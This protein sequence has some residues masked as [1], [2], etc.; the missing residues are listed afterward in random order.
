MRSVRDRKTQTLVIVQSEKQTRV[1]VIQYQ[2]NTSKII[3]ETAVQEENNII[4]E[5]A[6]APP[7]HYEFETSSIEEDS[8]NEE[9]EDG[10]DIWNY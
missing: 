3:R 6:D 5:A 8:V 10:M 7:E 4:Q 1:R 2:E 9:V